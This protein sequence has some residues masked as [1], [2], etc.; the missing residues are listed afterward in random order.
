M[1][2]VTLRVRHHGEPESDVSADHPDL[3]LRSVS[4]L[5]GSAAERKRIVEARGPADEI[6]AFLEEF[7][8]ASSVKS[9]EP[10]S[11]LDNDRVFVAVTYDSYQWDSIAQRLADHGVHYR[12]G[13]TIRA[14]W[15][16]WT[17][18]LEE[19][20]DLSAVV[21]SLEAAGNDTELMR[22]VALDEVDGEEHLALSRILEDLTDRQ[23]EVL[24]MATGMGYYDEGSDVRVEDIADEIGLAGTT[25]WEHLSRAEEK[26]MAE[27]GEY[28]AAR[29]H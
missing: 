24:A 18:Y 1:R 15:E 14:G 19:D 10:L 6:R 13:T 5:S 8:A 20:D 22:D 17:L 7:A 11:P 12:V 27:V 23:R 26:V 2:E 16:H 21:D 28:L 9:A 4:S 25:T 29:G 3:T